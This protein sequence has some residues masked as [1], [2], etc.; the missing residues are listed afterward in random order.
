MGGRRGDVR[1][2]G[3]VAVIVL[4]VLALTGAQGGADASVRQPTPSAEPI[5]LSGTGQEVTEPFALTGG[6]AVVR[7]EC[8]SCTDDFIVELLDDRRQVQDLVVNRIGS[9]EGT[10][11]V[12]ASAGDHVLQVNADAPWTVEITQPGDQPAAA[13]PQTW[14]GSGDRMQ[15]PFEAD[16]VV[17]VAA[18]NTGDGNFV[19]T[20]VDADGRSQ[21]LVFN[22]SGNFAGSAV[23]RMTSEGPYYVNVTSEGEWTLALSAP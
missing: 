7:S 13:L 17:T 16:R 12:A 14:A 21:D 8:P 3:V 18:A 6:L 1:V 19:V 11:G 5:T 4:L 2:G 22:E 10:K 20:V 9:Y 23:A 15:G